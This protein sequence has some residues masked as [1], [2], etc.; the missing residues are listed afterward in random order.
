MDPDS[1]DETQQPETTVRVVKSGPMVALSD[2]PVERYQ[3]HFVHLIQ[4]NLHDYDH[5]VLALDLA[6]GIGL[7]TLT[8]YPTLPEGSRVVALGDDR[9]D[10]KL[11]HDQIPKNL[12][13]LIFPRKERRERL[14]FATDIFDIVWASLPSEQPDPLRGI[15]RQ[16]LRVLRPGGQLAIAA[17]LRATFAELANAISPS[18][19]GHSDN[20]VFSALLSEPPQLLGSDDWKDNLQKC[21]AMEIQVIRDTIEMNIPPP[22]SSQLL[23]S[24]Y[25]LP[26]WLGDDPS[27]QAR[28]LRLLDEAVTDPLAI[29][30]HVGCI[31][32]R[33]GLSEIADDSVA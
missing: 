5:P 10:L 8:L 22:V 24:R 1:T 19:Q 17:P 20:E 14:P 3:H 4:R 13:H 6:C 16:A 12:R 29:T 25:L 11:F 18:L 23:F 30:I 21:G 7:P 2:D 9:A 26:L 28:A 31:L 33:R 15:L 27:M 32:S